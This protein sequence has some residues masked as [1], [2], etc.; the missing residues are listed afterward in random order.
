[1]QSTGMIFGNFES[2]RDTPK[3]NVVKLG[4]NDKSGGGSGKCPERVNG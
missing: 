2:D 4:E 1:M 3:R